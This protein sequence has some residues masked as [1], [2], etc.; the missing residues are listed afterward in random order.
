MIERTIAQLFTRAVGRWQGEIGSDGKPTE[1]KAL[2]V[3]FKIEK[4]SIQMLIH[5][6]AN[7]VGVYTRKEKGK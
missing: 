7:Y 1:R 6:P 4:K 5:A 3:L 2:L